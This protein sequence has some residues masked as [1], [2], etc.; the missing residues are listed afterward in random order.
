[1]VDDEGSESGPWDHFWNWQ[2]F[3]IWLWTQDLE[4]QFAPLF[5]SHNIKIMASVSRIILSNKIIKTNVLDT[6][7][8]SSKMNYWYTQVPELFLAPPK[9]TPTL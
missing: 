8:K 1:M 7:N 4:S 5:P 2:N 3:M 9:S 6:A